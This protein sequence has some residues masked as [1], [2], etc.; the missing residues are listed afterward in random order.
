MPGLDFWLD[1]RVA[2]SVERLRR[3]L[4]QVVGQA[5]YRLREVESTMTHQGWAQL[6][7]ESDAFGEPFGI[8]R[9][10]DGGD[11]RAQV[12]VAPGAAREPGALAALNRAALALYCGLLA[13]GLLA[14]PP[15]LETPSEP[16]VPSEA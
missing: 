13:R 10:Q 9:A 3:L 11:G 8:V 4:P 14:P 7:L 12:I 5:G 16:L 6:A 15:P 2:A 1:W